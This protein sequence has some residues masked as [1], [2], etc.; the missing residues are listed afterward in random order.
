MREHLSCDVLVHLFGLLDG[1]LAI[2]VGGGALLLGLL[3]SRRPILLYLVALVCNLDAH[4][5][6]NTRYAQA[7]VGVV[8]HVDGEVDRLGA[9][10]DCEQGEHWESN[11][12]ACGEFYQ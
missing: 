4:L 1:L 12:K 8:E 7:K 3:G 6:L 5:A 11:W 9:E 10:V 2:A